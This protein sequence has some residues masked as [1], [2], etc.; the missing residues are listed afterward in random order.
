MVGAGTLGTGTGLSFNS[1]AVAVGPAQTGNFTVSASGATNSPSQPGTVT[2]DVLDH[3]ST[4]TG[5][6]LGTLTFQPVRVGYVGPLSSTASLSVANAAGFRVNLQGVAPAP[7]GT[8]SLNGFNGVAPGSSGSITASLTSG[9]PQGAFS[10]GFTY[11]LGDDSTLNGSNNGALGTV[12]ITVT[13]NVYNGQGVWGSSGGGSW[14]TFAKWTM[15]G[16]YPGLD[17]AASI[18]DTATFGSNLSTGTVTLD[19]VSPLLS[20]LTFTST[21]GTI[22]QG[23]GSGTMTL[24]NNQNLVTP[25]VTVTGGSPIVSAPMVFTNTVTATTTGATDTL[26]LSGSITGPGGLTKT[27][28][29]TLFLTG[30]NGYL[31][32]TAVN[33]GTLSVP[34]EASLGTA[35]SSV[36]SDQ[37]S[38]DNGA[39]LAFTG[40]TNLSINQGI[41]VGSGGGTLDVA[42]NQTAVVN[43]AI[44]GT[45]TG[46]GTTTGTITKTGLGTLN[47]R[48]SIQAVFP[49]TA[50]ALTVSAGTLSLATGS[51]TATAFL[52]TGGVNFNGGTLAI[53]VFGTNGQGNLNG[54]DFL[55][56]DNGSASTVQTPSVHINAP[57]NLTISLGGFVPTPGETFTFLTDA[58][59][60]PS[61]P[62]YTNFFVVNG[63][64]AAPGVTVNLNGFYY[65]INYAGG[66]G[67]DMVLMSVIPEPGS[68]VMLLGGIGILGGIMRR[69]RRRNIPFGD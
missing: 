25:T 16:G 17:G 2:V 32:K 46:S 44:T 11:S 58:T 24:Q 62:L 35:P 39:K 67:G 4:P 9:Q 29:G 28:A 45:L 15:P 38:I 22:A 56:A 55:N 5:I 31:G 48:N 10:Q 60:Q 49:Q 65:Q 8:I 23:T 69:R 40:N 43:S 54:N 7:I 37:I 12:S 52:T 59:R 30:T 42:A 13:G 57:T 26:T 68:A 19:G 21:S 47:L 34:S 20:A 63:K 61:D 51:P 33:G 53:N 41:T 50:P 36:V 14:G 1:A 64:T 27:G 6:S 3:A 18:N 66:S